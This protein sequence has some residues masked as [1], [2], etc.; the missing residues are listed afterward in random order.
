[1]NKT[2]KQEAVQQ[3]KEMFEKAQGVVVSEFRGLTV[4]QANTL[5]RSLEK[6][7]AQHKVVKNTLARL[8]VEGTPY[9]GLRDAFVGPTAVSFTFE[10]P[11]AL[12]KAVT[13]FAKDNP[14][15]T[16]RCGGLPGKAITAAEVEAL[17]KLPSREQLLGQLVGVM[18]GPIRGLLGVLSGVPRGFVQVLS[19]IQQQKEAA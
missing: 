12:A 9:E 11:V 18:A 1:M 19:Q 8:A 10:D 7:G 16:I 5:R 3:L 15:L 6:E 14:A 17:S 2:Q 4:A 13:E